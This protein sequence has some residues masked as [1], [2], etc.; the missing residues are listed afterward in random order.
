MSKSGPKPKARM[1]PREPLATDPPAELRLQGRVKTIYKQLAARL[2]A[3]GYACAADSR[4]IAM[5][6]AATAH[7][8]RIEAATAALPTLTVIGSTGQTRVH[9]LLSELRAERAALAALLDRLFL[10]PKSRS[11][12]RLTEAQ[13]RTAATERDDLAEFLG[14]YDDSDR[15][16]HPPDERDQKDKSRFF[17]D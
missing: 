11:S 17:R 4:T 16:F 15:L 13:S 5:C 12:S 14:E 3:E 9:P 8:E 1:Q 2:A 6:A 7:V 10:N